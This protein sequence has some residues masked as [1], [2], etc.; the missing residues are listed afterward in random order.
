MKHLAVVLISLVLFGFTFAQDMAVLT[1]EE[2]VICTAIEDR[3]PTGAD[4]SFASDVGQLY[5]FTKISGA[6]DT[7]S[8]SHIW[9]F[10]GEEKA[11]VELNVKSKN[12]RTWSSKRIDPGWI[13]D[14]RV[15]VVSASGDVLSTRSFTITEGM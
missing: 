10:N 3:A 5:C 7:T 13:G 1:V 2:Q 4:S 12:W 15:E 6:E 14:W 9:Y 8:V 11:K